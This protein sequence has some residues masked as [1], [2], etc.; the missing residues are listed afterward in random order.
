MDTNGMKIR[1]TSVVQFSRKQ[2]NK[3]TKRRNK[4]DEKNIGVKTKARAA[5]A[6]V[7]HRARRQ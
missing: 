1:V 7:D 2:P 6:T 5:G 4:N 3:K